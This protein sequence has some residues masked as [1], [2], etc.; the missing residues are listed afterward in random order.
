MAGVATTGDRKLSGPRVRHA[1]RDW[2]AIER[3]PDAR[4][5]HIP[6]DIGR[7]APEGIAER[8]AS[9]MCR[10]QCRGH[11]IRAAPKEPGRFS[12]NI[13]KRVDARI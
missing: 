4:R 3:G 13:L 12:Q 7:V 8:M 10:R 11:Q 1:D 5:A 9:D 2:G 6:G